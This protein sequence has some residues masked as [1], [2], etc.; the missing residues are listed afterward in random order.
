M[1]RLVRGEIPIFQTHQG[2][3]IHMYLGVFFLGQ[4]HLHN[5]GILKVIW[6]LPSWTIVPKFIQG[7]NIGGLLSSIFLFIQYDKT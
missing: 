7:S 4:P 6:S 2:V 1:F 5:K 3:F